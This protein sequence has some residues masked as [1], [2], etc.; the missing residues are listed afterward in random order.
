VA[1]IAAAAAAGLV[2][3]VLLVPAGFVVAVAVLQLALVWA[4]MVGTDL[5]GLTVGV[6]LGATAAAAGDVALLSQTGHGL[7]PLVVLLGAVFPLLLVHQ[8]ARGDGRHR[9]AESLSGVAAGCVAGSGLA[10]YLELARYSRRIAVAAV[11]AALLGVLA[12]ALV[13]AVLRAEAF[14]EGV[15]HGLGGVVTATL[16]GVVVA[17]AATRAVPVQP[18]WAA[19]LGGAVG[20]CAALVAVG[21]GYI[22]W[23]VE[24]GRAAFAPVALP[25][26]RVLLPLSAAAPVAYLLGVAVVR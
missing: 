15:F 18:V 8:L 17:V 16:A 9:V 23:S 14:A 4:W 10:L 3:V 5:P 6:V 11:L 2:G 19:L 1:G 12:A 7:T 20:L 22:T 21:A 26:L 24:P 13:D 25:V